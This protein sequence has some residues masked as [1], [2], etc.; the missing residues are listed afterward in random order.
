MSSPVYDGPLATRDVESGYASGASSEPGLPDVYFSKPHLKFLNS[1]LQKLEPHDILQWCITSL[2]GLYQTTAFGLTGLAALDM[3]SKL[4]GLI[5]PNVDLI[6]LDTLH[7]FDETLALVERVRRRYS[8]VNTHIY[9]PADC[10]TAEDFSTKHG[11]RLWEKNEELYDYVAKV[12]PAQRAYS[13]LQ[14]KAVLTGR[15][16]SQGGKRGDLDIIEVDE[17]GLIK[18]NPLAN[19]SFRQV[20]DYIK[21]NNVPYN[22][23]L[24]NGY[25]SVG[26]WHSTQPIVEGEDER[27]GRWKGRAKTE[28]GIHNPKSKYAQFLRQ[29]ELKR[30]EEELSQALQNVEVES[31]QRELWGDICS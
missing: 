7:H 29:Q 1:Q 16:R 10:E 28:C 8:G 14:V 31:E 21:A 27:S 3:L 17:A 22:E 6:F 5:K 9:K 25:K 4:S 2:P 18:V 24:N 26:D 19:W 11:E 20:Q 12:E 30:Q 23:L 13:E 15:R